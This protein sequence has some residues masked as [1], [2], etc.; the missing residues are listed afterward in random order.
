MPGYEPYRSKDFVIFGSRL[1]LDPQEAWLRIEK[2]VRTAIRKGQSYGPRIEK[3]AGTSE[4]IALFAPFCPNR[5]DLPERLR[6]TQHLFFAFLG[7]ALAGGIIVTE[8]PDRLYLHFHAATEEGKRHHVPSVLLWHIVEAFSG[9]RFRY[10]DVGASYRPSLQ[11]YFSSFAT[12]R[13]PVIMRPPVLPPR[14]DITPFDGRSLLPVGQRPPNLAATRGAVSAALGT[15]AWTFFPRGMYAIHALF[16]SLRDEGAIGPEDEVCIRTT[17]ESPYVSSCV[18]SAIEQTCRW[19]RTLT[20]RTRAIFVIHE[21]GFPHPALADLRAEADTRRI[22]LIED[23]AYAWG[24]AGVGYVGDFAVYSL[25]KIFP[26]QFGGL[27]VGKRFETAEVWQRFGC[28]DENKEQLIL[29]T[30]AEMLPRLP[31]A[32][33]ARLANEVYYRG[34]FGDARALFGAPADGVSPGA[35]VLRMRDERDMQETSAF[36]RSFGIECGNYWQN[37][38]IFLPVHQHLTPALRDYVAGAVFGAHAYE[39]IVSR[40]ER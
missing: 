1:L 14:I 30:V 15:D 10:L 36:V 19:S 27:L 2:R 22:P 26:V 3:R 9:S 25:P 21:F 37:A 4:D 35:F 39:R 12:E 18:T 17:T 16:R 6:P 32:R 29:P 28:A 11:K 7:D 23:C 33:A 34:L 24:T 8:L 13:Y 38:A 5:D 40:M 20:E 31:E